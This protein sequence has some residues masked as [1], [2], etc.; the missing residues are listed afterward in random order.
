L[1]FH[2]YFTYIDDARSN[3]NQMKQG[4]FFV[5]LVT[6]SGFQISKVQCLFLLS[7]EHNFQDLERVQPYCPEQSIA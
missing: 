6:S 3:T 2:I 5:C 7:E 4:F 1:E